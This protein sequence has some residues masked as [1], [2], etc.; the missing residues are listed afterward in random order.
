MWSCHLWSPRP[1]DEIQKVRRPLSAV[2]AG[3]VHHQVH[4]WLGGIYCT[5]HPIQY[6]TLAEFLVFQMCIHSVECFLF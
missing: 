6:A 2:R 4:V 1:P 3:G 5:I